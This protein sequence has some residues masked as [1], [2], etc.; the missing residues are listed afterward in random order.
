MWSVENNSDLVN[1]MPEYSVILAAAGSSNRF[2]DQHYKKP[3]ANLDGKAVWLHSADQFLKRNDVKQLIIVI[4]QADHEDFMSRFGANVAVLGIDVVI[5]GKERCHSIG[6]ALKQVAPS[7]D[8]VAIHDA[9]RP[10]IGVEDIE[11]VFDAATRKE[12]AILATPV[13]STVKRAAQSGTAIEST[14]DRD[15]LWLASTPQVFRRELIQ[16]AYDEIADRQP[17]DEAQ[18]LEMLGH[19]VT[20]VEGSPLNI[21]ITTRQDLRFA[22]ACLKA[23]PAPKLDAPAHPFADDNLWR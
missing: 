23:M 1:V 4:A 3:F 15:G 18:L 22:G 20:I 6:N 7:A 2:Q 17:T 8:F 19:E 21:K 5:G 13:S 14:V 11:A 16:S 10:C 9:A 12:A